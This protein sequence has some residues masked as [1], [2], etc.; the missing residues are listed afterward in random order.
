MGLTENALLFAFSWLRSLSRK[1]F[2][3]VRK[4]LC[5][6]SQKSKGVLDLGISSY[7]L[8][9]RLLLVPLDTCW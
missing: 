5:R 2:L 4:W 8:Q 6:C 1:I 9:L 7:H 3:T